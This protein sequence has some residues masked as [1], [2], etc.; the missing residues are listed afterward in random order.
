MRQFGQSLL[1]Q[2]KATQESVATWMD[3]ISCYGTAAALCLLC[4]LNGDK[5]VI[6]NGEVVH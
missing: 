1:M 3:K 2:I 6:Y 4:L 5:L